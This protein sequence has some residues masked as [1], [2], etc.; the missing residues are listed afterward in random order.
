M[1][2]RIIVLISAFTFAAAMQAGA[3]SIVIAGETGKGDI[4]VSVLGGKT[5]T[6]SGY[7]KD[8]AFDS[9]GPWVLA[10]AKP[11]MWGSY[12]V[13]H[14]Q[15]VKKKYTASDEGEYSSMAMRLK[16]TSLV[17]AGT[18]ARYFNKNGYEA[19]MFGEVNFRRMYSTEYERKS[20]KRERFCGFVTADGAKTSRPKYDLGAQDIMSEVFHVFDCDYYD[21]DIYATGWG[22]WEYT[23]N[24]GYTNYYVRRC[25][26]VWKNGKEAVQQDGD[27][28]GAAYSI[29]VLPGN[30][31][32]S[33]HKEGNARGWNGSRDDIS[34]SKEAPVT[35]EAVLVTD[36][37]N[38]NIFKRLCLI[39]GKLY[40]AVK[41]QIVSGLPPYRF[42]DVVA[43]ASNRVF[44]AVCY[45]TEAGLLEVW[46]ILPD[47][48]TGKKLG[49]I[50]NNGIST[51]KDDIIK[52]A[53]K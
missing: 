44:Y 5:Y 50:P 24:S 37:Q 43:D 27:R 40:S 33:G 1:K 21:G 11:D 39:D 9:A 25:A 38:S 49:S 22:E 16:G 19:K 10:C 7:L 46:S 13:Y 48:G 34:F 36:N 35:A 30:I 41:L 23:N 8:L 12:T 2:K 45:N 14:N 4:K 53:F 51:G 29:N 42:Y 18:I 52:I 28:T 17:I 15:E 47:G 31:L 3:Q 6:V 20:L 26:R 32:T